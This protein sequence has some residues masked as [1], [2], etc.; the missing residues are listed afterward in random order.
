[1]TPQE[2]IL[3]K[4]SLI[5]VISDIY[6]RIDA[7][8]DLAQKSKPPLNL[9]KATSNDIVVNNIIWYKDDCDKSIYFWKIVDILS[10][11]P[12]NVFI[13]KILERYCYENLRNPRRRNY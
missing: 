6:K 9:R 3:I 1:M 10:P 2:Y 7:A 8:E 13:H 11:I 5:K 4:K 12:Y